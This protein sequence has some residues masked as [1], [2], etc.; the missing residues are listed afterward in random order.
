MTKIPDFN[1]ELRKIS[2]E[3]ERTIRRDDFPRKIF[4]PFL[5]KS[6]LDYPLR[7]GKRLRPA[8]LR[9]TCGLFGGENE[10]AKFAAA[11]V[12]I[13][14]NWTL[15]HDDIIDNGAT[16]KG[17][18][19]THCVLANFA[20]SKGFSDKDAKTF[21]L[22]QA[23]LSGDIQHAWAMNIL[24][25]SSS[26]GVS[27][28]TVVELA[29]MLT[30]L[31]G[32]DLISGEALDVEISFKNWSKVSE[33]DAL[34]IAEMKTGALLEFCARCGALIALDGK[35]KR[36]ADIDNI[37]NFAKFTG[38]AFQ[39]KDDWLGVFGDKGRIGKPLLSDLSAKKPTFLF[40]KTLSLAGKN[41]VS[42]LLSMAGKEKYS[43]RQISIVREIARNCGA[44]AECLEKAE[45][46]RDKALN[47]LM[48]FPESDSRFLLQQ[49]AKLLIERNY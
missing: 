25:K 27:H 10:N 43:D 29:K 35:E 28:E 1:A 23:I 44:E 20:K 41:E 15:V 3:T 4:P 47:L 45:Q 38:M 34:K 18:P 16:R 30:V 17:E 42:V 24:L 2:A 32:R 13:F 11:A 31:G 26:L 6:A 33:K 37:A 48:K 5:K 49:W 21:G 22:A 9:W 36:T 19:S 12:E 8:L 7:K 14:H 40:L 46:I 39:L